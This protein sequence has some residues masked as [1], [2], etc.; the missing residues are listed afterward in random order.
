[1]RRISSYLSVL[2]FLGLGACTD[3]GAPMFVIQ[4][5]VP[6]SQCVPSA[7]R[8][9]AFLSAGTVDVNTGGGYLM[10]PLVQNIAEAIPGDMSA[11]RITVQGADVEL[12]PQDGFDIGD[13]RAFTNRFSGTIAANNGL[14][15]FTFEAIPLSVLST[16]AASGQLQQPNDRGQIDVK[17]TVFGQMDGSTVESEEFSFPVFVCRGCLVNDLGDCANL[18][19]GFSTDNQGF[20]DPN[21][22]QDAVVDCCK[23]GGQLICPAEGP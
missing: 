9:G 4:N 8:T 11:R 6:D 21:R 1:M 23:S 15:A 12:I 3:A 7:A 20:C 10:F 13:Q 19:A 14:T 5:Q 16:I 2:A 18:G 22:F 17:V